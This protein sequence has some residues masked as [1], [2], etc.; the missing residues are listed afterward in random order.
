M[1]DLYKNFI[2]VLLIGKN[3]KQFKWPSTTEQINQTQCIQAADCSPFSSTKEQITDMHCSRDGPQKHCELKEGR[4]KSLH[5][6]I[7]FV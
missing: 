2:A 5:C 4:F 1:K 7:S 3:E 6:V